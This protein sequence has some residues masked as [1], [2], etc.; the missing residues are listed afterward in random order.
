MENSIDREF[1]R[2]MKKSRELRRVPKMFKPGMNPIFFGFGRVRVYYFSGGSGL[3]NCNPTFFGFGRV[4]VNHFSGGSGSGWKI[5]EMII[6]YQYNIIYFI[7]Q[8]N[9]IF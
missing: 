2:I 1:Q 5:V 3:L 6:F 8:F 4:R 7:F 9:L